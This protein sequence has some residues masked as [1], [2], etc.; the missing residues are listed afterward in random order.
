ME[1]A[2]SLVVELKDDSR[3]FMTALKAFLSLGFHPLLLLSQDPPVLELLK[4][5][6]TSVQNYLVCACR[7]EVVR[8][9]SVNI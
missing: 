4:K 6:H 9:V 8:S 2:W 5:V 1:T 7:A 3:S